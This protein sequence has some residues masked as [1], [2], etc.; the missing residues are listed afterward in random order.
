MLSCG[1]EWLPVISSSESVGTSV[2]I[3]FVEPGSPAWFA[4][5]AAGDIITSVDSQAPNKETMEKLSNR[6][7]NWEKEGREEEQERKS[8]SRGGQRR[9]SKG[10][11]GEI[12]TSSHSRMGLNIT[13]SIQLV[14]ISSPEKEIRDT[15]ISSL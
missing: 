14:Y 11:T 1:I 13:S 6:S 5:L 15:S 8:Y 7:I 3:T 10:L 12:G 4:G 9:E 2:C